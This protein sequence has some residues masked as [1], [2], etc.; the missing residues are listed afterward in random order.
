MHSKPTWIL[1]HFFPPP[2]LAGAIGRIVAELG[3][4][5]HKV[6]KRTG[7]PE[8]VFYFYEMEVEKIEERWPEMKK[9][10]RRWF[11]YEDARRAVSK[12]AMRDAIDKCS[13]AP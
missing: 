6:N 3:E 4:Y 5:E 2:F 7:Y 13:L 10:E 11:S 9:R 1:G 8:T 12:K